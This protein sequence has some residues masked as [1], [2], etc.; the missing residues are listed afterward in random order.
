MPVPTLAWAAVLGLFL[1]PAPAGGA[2]RQTATFAGGCFWCMEGPFEKLPG[3]HSAISGYTGGQKKKPT[4]E[5]V[6]SGGTGHAE[7][8]Q[9][10][11]DPAK[12]SYEK[13]LEVFWHNIDPLQ[14]N[15][16]FCDR[17]SQYRSAIF[18]HDEAQKAAALESKRALEAEGRL[19]KPIVT[20]I[21]AASVFYPAEE[22][23]QDFYKRNPLRYNSYRMGCGRDRRL[24]ELWGDWAGG[25]K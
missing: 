5:E 13:L 8:V 6:S 19:A 10:V 15:A 1:I 17:G 16:Q 23:H 11:Y 21:V 25:G 3:V 14:A 4:Y 9:V 20:E 2:E 18:Y 12:V 22:Y 7:A 24:K